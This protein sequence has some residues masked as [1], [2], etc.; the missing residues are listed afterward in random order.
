MKGRNALFEMKD[1]LEEELMELQKQ[2]DDINSEIKRRESIL[3]GLDD[4]ILNSWKN[5]SIKDTDIETE[6]DLENEYEY[7]LQ[8]ELDEECEFYKYN[9]ID[10]EYN[11]NLYNDL[12]MPD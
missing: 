6:D 9:N 11:Y 3:K 12:Y 8:C 5:L 1:L 4:N 7:E 10:A 2:R